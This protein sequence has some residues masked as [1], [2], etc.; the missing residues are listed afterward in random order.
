MSVQPVHLNQFL[1]QVVTP[2]W[3]DLATRAFYDSSQIDSKWL[4]PLLNAA[5]RLAES[6]PD[7]V[8]RFLCSL[9]DDSSK[10]PNH[11][12]LICLSARNAGRGALGLVLQVLK[13][14]QTDPAIVD[15]AIVAAMETDPSDEVFQ[16]FADHLLNRSC[17]Q[18]LSPHS[19][20]FIDLLV[21]WSRFRRIG[22]KVY[23]ATVL[24]DQCRI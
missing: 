8:V 9:Y 24:Q 10:D 5:V 21:G 3:L 14:H 11:W 22:S 18:R 2:K 16:G 7:E 20:A 13:D 15:F 1:E 19:R 6:H 17:W 4:Q 12:R 23:Q